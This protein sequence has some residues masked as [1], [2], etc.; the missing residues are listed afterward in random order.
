MRQDLADITLIVDRSGS[1]ASIMKDAEGG[2]N[3]LIK[4]QKETEGRAN[5]TLIQFDTDYEFI[6]NGT[7][8]QD[9]GT[10]T[11][12]PRGMTAL[13]DAVGRGIAETGERLS[14][15]RKRD[16]PALV[17]FVIVTDGY[18]NSSQEY[19]RAQIKE[20][21]E[22]QREKYNWQFLFLCA[23]AD[24]FDDAVS[25]GINWQN[26][27]MYTGQHV[28]STYT[29]MSDKIS[30]TRSAYFVGDADT[31]SLCFTDSERKDLTS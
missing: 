9:V 16:R 25:W 24:T 11:L 17:M 22:H 26:T 29:L 27:A 7:D 6:Y 8:I 1:M 30:Q 5:F 28:G 31:T 15:M 18:E 21:I 14:K 10:Y 19:T 12:K 3:Q 23:D 20:M 13:L 2:I 4:E